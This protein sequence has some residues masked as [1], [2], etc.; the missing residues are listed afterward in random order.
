MNIESRAFNIKT[1]TPV[2]IGNGNKYNGISYLI[3]EDNYLNKIDSDFI[4]QNLNIEEQIKFVEWLEKVSYQPSLNQFLENINRSDIIDILKDKNKFPK[5]KVDKGFKK[6]VSEYIKSDMNTVYIPGS[7]IKGSIRTA[8]A[9]N[10][11]SNNPEILKD[12]FNKGFHCKPQNA[13]DELINSIFNCGI[14]KSNREIDY[15]DSKYDLLKLLKISDTQNLDYGCMGIY[16][17]DIFSQQKKGEL[18]PKQK[19]LYI[20]AIQEG[21]KNFTINIEIDRNFLL[22]AKK[23]ETTKEW[24]GLNQKFERIFGTKLSN[25]KNQNVE[26]IENTIIRKIKDAINAFSLSIINYYKRLWEGQKDLFIH[27]NCKSVVDED[28]KNRYKKYCHRCR[29]GHLTSKDLNSISFERLQEKLGFLENEIQNL[30][31]SVYMVLGFGSGFVGTTLM[32]LL[33]NKQLENVRKNYELGKVEYE[34]YC[35]NRHCGKFLGT[36]FATKVSWKNEAKRKRLKCASCNTD[37]SIKKNLRYLKKGEQPKSLIQKFPKTQRIAYKNG[38][39]YTP[40]GW[41]ELSPL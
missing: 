18:R 11:I 31:E 20:E 19:D 24:I 36:V 30:D 10:A 14:I 27:K 39:P 35:N 38:L 3:D 41:I 5:I 6:D 1:L 7:S 29:V 23:I 16:H 13:D 4:F 32:E 22:E 12:I 15:K 9:Y 2:H 26:S 17:Y 28:F 25:L 37:F 8:L 33:N 40:F 34:V 21:F